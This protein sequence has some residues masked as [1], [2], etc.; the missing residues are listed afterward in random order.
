YESCADSNARDMRS[1]FSKSPRGSSMKIRI[2]C[3]LLTAFSATLL[4]AQDTASLTGTVRDSSGA[5]IPN[6]AVKVTSADRGI[7]R[8][9]TT[10]SD[11]EY[12]VAALTPGSYD[13]SVSA[14]GFKKY[15]AK[16]VIL[17]VG[18]KARNDVTMQVGATSTQV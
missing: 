14:Q 13:V 15:E 8:E 7:N 10:N 18:Q 16:G 12:A 11:G 2:F 6:A 9:T 4:Q 17:R 3:L 5:S 1:V